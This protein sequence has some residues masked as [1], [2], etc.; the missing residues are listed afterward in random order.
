MKLLFLNCGGTIV[1]EHSD[2][3]MA[4]TASLANLIERT[5][6]DIDFREEELFSGL[7]ANFTL[8]DIMQVAHVLHSADDVAGT[9]ITIGTDVA[10]EVGFA[11]DY[12]GPYPGPVVLVG[13]SKPTQVQGYDGVSNL[14]NAITALQSSALR[15]GDVVFT[16][17][18]RFFDAS[19][20]FKQDSELLDGFSASPGPIGEMRNGQ[21]SIPFN[22]SRDSATHGVTLNDGKTFEKI[23]RIGVLMTHVDM[24]LDTKSLGRLDGLVIAGM[25]TG[26]MPD[27]VRSKIEEDLTAHIPCV[28]STRCPSGSAFNEYFYRNSTEKLDRGRFIYREFFT[29]NYL[30]ARMKLQID[31]SAR[32]SG[33]EVEPY[34]EK[35]FTR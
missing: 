26:S 7:A 32:M 29:L 18:D 25:G 22:C 2:A 21:A 31:L 24:D 19:R 9:I 15:A 33:F 27:D 17:A 10:E 20:L 14:Y 34:L 6:L 12:L 5:G 11:I 8:R 13:A 30:K 16:I 35:F 1:Q 23:A 28:V 3:K 4:W